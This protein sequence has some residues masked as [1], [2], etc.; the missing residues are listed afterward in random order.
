MKLHLIEFRIADTFTAALARLQAAEQKAAKITA[1][2]LQ[3]D[4]AAPGLRFH[5]IE[6]SRDPNFW[7]VR[8]SG[9]LRIIVHKTA[10]SFL[11][12]YVGHHDDSYAW[13]ER[14]RIE[15]HPRTGALQ[16]VEV[17]ERVEDLPPPTP[18]VTPAAAPRPAKP[19]PFAALSPDTLLGLGVPPDWLA[20]VT[21]ATEDG[22]LAL[23][24]HLPAEAAEA[25][26]EYA[27]TGRLRP[28]APEPVAPNP[29]AHPDALRRF[30]V[31]ENQ[32]ELAQ[33]LDQPWDRWIVFL[34]PAQAG[35]VARSFAGPARV[36]GSAGTGKTVVAL[37]RAAR[38]ARDPD[39]RVLLTTFSQ[40]LA[41][42]L[43]WR[44]RAL[45]GAAPG[46][47]PRVTVA[48]FRT[49]ADELHQL[50]F[51]RRAVPTSDEQVRDAVTKA[52]E[53]AGNT[54]YPL[55]FLLSEWRHVVDAW[56]I[57]DVDAYSRVPRLGRKSRMSAGQRER[58]WPVFAATRASLARR[59]LLT[60]PEIF[61]RTAAHYAERAAKPFT[62]VVVDEAQDLGVPELRFMAAIA[63]AGPDALFFAGDG[64]QRIFQQPF[65][66][67]ALG[68]DVRGRSSTLTVNYRTSHQIRRAADRLLPAAVQDVDG[69]A[70]ARDRTV[71]IF[72]GPDPAVLRATD[73]AAEIE[74][75]AAWLRQAVADGIAPM[76]AG[77]FVRSRAELDRARAA[78]IRAGLEPFDLS[79][80]DEAPAG[81]TPVGTMH[82]AK[83]LEF[84][85]VAVMACDDDVLPL[86]A[87]VEGVADEVELDEVYETERHLLYVACTRARDRLLIS[88][89]TPASEFFGDLGTFS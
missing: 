42:A 26:L 67:A 59:G 66:W 65:S 16:I 77:V 43:D 13:A 3:A 31:V 35:L 10:R 78:V 40:P 81:R 51:G 36:Q 53:A 24:D 38:H 45:A 80:R 11:L 75:V 41:S 47:V 85:A 15:A 49:V 12:A 46:V 72:N 32:A 2:D 44:L 86:R 61:A 54:G 70:D 74:A 1:Y 6:R 83:G 57:A 69:V 18:A 23:C 48:P 76:E 68:V 30:R 79:E 7:S 29:F 33:A 20:D 34:H 63:P 5:R 50:A 89:V 17:R 21:A 9:E 84:K 71:S 58:L 55:R 37:H 25:L 73:A 88:G 4:P 82:L 8:A 27:T 28:A 64:G 19:P 62:H 52:A 87:R 39:A 56:G 14:R 60:W 22:F